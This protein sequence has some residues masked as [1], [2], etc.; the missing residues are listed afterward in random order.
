M[1]YYLGIDLG[2]T[3]IATGLVNENFNII[4][5]DSVKTNI[6]RP[7]NEIMDDMAT[8][9]L[10]VV[11]NA[12]LTMDDIECVGVGAPGT[13][14]SKTGMID[15]SNNLFLYDV[16]LR[17]YLEKKLNMKV[18]IENDANAAAYGE[19]IAGSA[20]GAKTAVL[21]TI[22]TGIGSGIVIDNKIY[23]GFNFAGAELGHSVIVQNGNECT[24]GRKGCFETYGSATALINMTKE[25]MLK[26]KNTIMWQLCENDIEN[27]SG[28]TSFKAMRQNDQA[29]KNVVN[30]YIKYLACGL[31]NVINVFQPNILCIGGGICKEGDAL[32]LPIKEIIKKEVFSRHSKQQTEI[33]IA[34][35]GNDAGIIGAAML[36]KIKR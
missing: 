27:V 23:T 31:T 12:G 28:K 19:Y 22:G 1:N 36:N 33:V 25:A 7:A 6:P 35:L 10:S 5:K 26:D 24:C 9:A 2:G 32:L 20:K 18:Y 4:A 14:N 13:V 29:G 17:E 30:T 34:S 3:N 16:P 21:I 8:V 15:F 11:K